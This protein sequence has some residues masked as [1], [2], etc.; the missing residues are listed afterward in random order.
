MEQRNRRVI[1]VDE[2]PA[3]VW[4]VGRSLVRAGFSV[5]TCGDG[6][7]ALSLLETQDFDVLI[8]DIRLLKVG[9]L[10]LVDWARSN[11]PAIKV[12]VTAASASPVI[13]NLAIT[14]GALLYLEKPVDTDLL[15]SVLSETNHDRAFSG[16]IDGIDILDYVQLMLLSQRQVVLEVI[17]HD[18]DRGLLY[19]ARGEVHHA[20]CG[21]FEGEDAVYECL[22]FP[23]GNFVNLPWTEP[24]R[25]TVDKPGRF[26][27][28]EAARLRDERR[29]SKP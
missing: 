25:I 15:V 12:I 20:V 13:R 6:E 27:L 2:D 17:S 7:D 28:L 29:D 8:T 26:L 3:V 9:G 4:A 18:G 23:G 22:N 5:V 16:S 21:T 1:L 19:I 14:R 10:A 24:E 11:K